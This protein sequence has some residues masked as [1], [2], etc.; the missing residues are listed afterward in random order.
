M[1]KFADTPRF[2][3][4]DFI[5]LSQERVD[6]V[7]PSG[8]LWEGAMFV[9]WT[10]NGN[11]LYKNTSI[12]EAITISTSGVLWVDR[13]EIIY[14][15][16][17]EGESTQITDN[18]EIQ[19]SLLIGG[20]KN[21][22]IITT[23]G[24]GWMDLFVKDEDYG[25]RPISV[26]AD[27]TNPIEDD[28][29]N[30]TQNDKAS[31][32]QS[33]P[34]DEWSITEYSSGAGH[35]LL[36]YNY[37]EDFPYNPED[38]EE[39]YFR[40]DSQYHSWIRDRAEDYYKDKYGEDFDL[41][42]YMN[43]DRRFMYFGPIYKQSAD[44]DERK[45][46]IIYRGFKNY[47]QEAIPEHQVTPNYKTYSDTY[48]DMVNNE[49]YYM[50]KDMW[51]LIDPQEV[52]FRFLDYIAKF[53]NMST[54]YNVN[55][56]T[57]L[58]EFVA[59]IIYLLKRK[60]AYSSIYILWK[61]LSRGS[62][63]DLNLYERWHSKD[64]F[65]TVPVSAW[66]DY[67]YTLAYD[68]STRS[69]Y[70]SAYADDVLS[71][72]DIIEIDL[73]TEPLDDTVIF[74]KD[75]ADNL[76]I[77]WETVRPVTRVMDYRIYVEPETDFSGNWISL[78]DTT[79]NAAFLTQAYRFNLALDGAA[80]QIVEPLDA[81]TEWIIPHGLNT[82]DI[83]YQVFD[84][85]LEALYP[86]SFEIIDSYTVRLTFNEPTYGVVFMAKAEYTATRS[87]D[88][89]NSFLIKHL[90]NQKEVMVNVFNVSRESVYPEDIK[91][92]NEDFIQTDFSPSVTT[93]ARS[94]TVI[95][96][97]DEEQKVWTVKHDLGYKGVIVT[98][99]DNNNEMIVPEKIE[100]VDDSTTKIHFYEPIKG[101]AYIK[102]I[103]S[104]SF[105]DNLIKVKTDIDGNPIYDEDGTLAYLSPTWRVSDNQDFLETW[106]YDGVVDDVEE[107]DEYY[108]FTW[109][110]NKGMD[111]E[112]N[113][114]GLV[115]SIGEVSFVSQIDTIVKPKEYEFKVKYR[116]KKTYIS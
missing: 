58:R 21:S 67:K 28:E 106:D 50:L 70:P 42:K 113:E 114:L 3:I 91:F 10:N 20:R 15:M 79:K 8:Y 101:Y 59:N 95:S 16:Y 39:T 86:A 72:N 89:G 100:L 111:I 14:N 109:T 60:G 108:Y 52:D 102:A 11:T 51:S 53:Y 33:L 77:N 73:S 25:F 64:I 12:D 94:D 76:Y 19:G 57:R 81:S 37:Q 4:E 105:R 66:K 54:E 71:T 5:G 26:K 29:F 115:N 107:D 43:T 9:G 1:T 38:D 96:I 61:L 7:V 99:S 44:G 90:R 55:E 97:Q 22:A 40:K 87:T 31:L 103:G 104:P 30:Y 2:T 17:W 56:E 24:N 98:C 74:S 48:Y 49:P 63:N 116:V 36:Y 84:K 82:T 47:Q 75:V 92:I 80:I 93:I 35:E 65:G 23:G 112:I 68:L 85:D 78:Y 83:V 46:K 41:R 45:R 88:Q 110:I 62:R 27:E 32:V 6:K 69:E 34:E 13:K 18:D